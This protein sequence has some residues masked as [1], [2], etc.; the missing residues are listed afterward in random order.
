MARTRIKICGIT[1][2]EA[3]TGAANAGADAVGFVFA[4][5]SPRYIHPR[6]AWKLAC[7]LPPMVSSVGLYVNASL[8]EFAEIEQQ[9]PTMMTQ[10]HGNEPDGVVIELGPEL[11]KAVKF[12][13]ETIADRLAHYDAI[14][15]VSVILVDGSEGGE[16]VAFDWA[17]LA[18]ASRDIKT[19]IML[20]GGLDASNVG[21]AIAAV[22]PYAVDVS[23]GV[24]SEQGVKDLDKIRAFCKAVQEADSKTG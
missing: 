18:D 11:I 12:D 19:P 23:S 17:K 3:L 8:D 2:Q 15:E 21:D 22:R 5:S 4:E 9:C 14:E 24:E 20:A 7:D 10:L 1:T 6:E 16:G 13:P